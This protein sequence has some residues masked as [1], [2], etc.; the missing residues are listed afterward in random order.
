LNQSLSVSELNEQIKGLLE[1]TF[2]TVYV[3]GEI[4]NLTYHSSGHIY[5]SVK[6]KKSTVSCVMFRGN[7]AYLKFRLEVGMKIVISGNITVYVPRGNY[8]LLCTK[9]E[10]E[11]VGSLALAYEQ[12]KTK[13]QIKGYFNKAIKKELPLHPKVI[14]VITSNTGAAIE[15]MKKI[16]NTWYP[17][18]KMI[19]LST[20]VQGEGAKESIALNIN[21]VSNMANDKNDEILIVGRGGGSMEDLWAFNE[22]MVAQAIYECKIAVISAVGHE[23]DFVIS[24][25]VAD[26]RASTPSNAIELSTPNINDL[27]MYADTLS[28]EFSNKYKYI[29]NNKSMELNN[30]KTSFA[31]HSLTRKFELVQNSISQMRQS[32]NQNFSQLLRLNENKKEMLK[33]AF[34]QNHPDKKSKLGYVQVTK[35]FSLININDSKVNDN[36]DLETSVYKFSC[37]ITDKIKLN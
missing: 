16:L 3:E 2:C 21:T 5:F 17:L 9:I 24:Y 8:Q 32:Y 10:P 6:D 15:D 1:T 4:S 31:Q 22:E 28:N 14:Y 30:L 7:A 11:G 34:M 26:V 18:A 35:D 13:L 12:L 36:V 23:N 37:I 19:L 27:R 25:M 29:I 33:N 20:L